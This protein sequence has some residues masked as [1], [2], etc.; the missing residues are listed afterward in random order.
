MRGLI[1]SWRDWLAV[2]GLA[3]LFGP[4]SAAGSA[5]EVKGASPEQSAIRTATVTRGDLV[6]TIT[7]NGTVE[8]E[9]LV[10]VAAPVAGTIEKFGPDPRGKTDPQ[11]QGKPID[12]GSPVEE[13]TVL[14]KLSDGT[15]MAQVEQAKAVCARAEAEMALAKT[16]LELAEAQ[17]RRGQEQM[18]NQSI[19]ASDLDVLKADHG[20]A[21]AS[22]SIAGATLAQTR[23]SL[24]Q[25]EINLANT[26]IKSPIR[27]VV[28]DRRVN[29]GQAA[30]TGAGA[31][32]LFL[33]ASDLSRMQVWVSINEADIARIRQ[34]QPARFSVDAY[35]GKSFEG[36]VSQIRLNAAVVQNVVTYTV[37]LSA[38]NP[39]GKLLPYLTANVRLEVERHKGAILVPNAALRWRPEPRWI[40]PEA[41]EKKPAGSERSGSDQGQ[42]GM[43]RPPGEAQRG[44]V[45]IR[46]GEFVRP[47]AVVIGPSDGTMTQISGDDVKEGLEVIVSGAI[48][49][50]KSS[51]RP[52]TDFEKALAGMGVNQLVVLP[53]EPA[54]SGA[55]IVPSNRSTLTVEDADEI[56]RQC[57]A[58]V[59]AAPVIRAR[60][61]V[62][63]GDCS[64]V[65]LS[66]LG[67]TPS[68]L[69]A[70][71]WDE[72]SEGDAFTDADVRYAKQVCLIGQ[73]LKRE[74][75]QGESPIGK[76]VR[77]ENVPF[78]VVGVL[79]RKGA[80]V[81]GL[82]QDDIMLAPWSTVRFRGSHSAPNEA[83]AGAG[84]LS[85]NQAR[86]LAN[87]YPG[88]TDRYGS[89]SSAQPVDAV[90]LVRS[91]AV[92][93]IL[94]QAASA[95]QVPRAIE[96]ITELLRQRHRIQRGKSDDFSVRDL[97]E[98]L[99][100]INSTRRW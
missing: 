90:Q 44:R 54:S 2:V 77:V 38:D 25:A 100:A 30:V 72:I 37:V 53:R 26:T 52:K 79:G 7:A 89:P 74:L 51:Q 22:I 83:G 24:K 73:T 17:W 85:A 88:S 49:A 61:A 13:G 8:A 48:A 47:I 58:V 34:Q 12:F 63:L 40:V 91:I 59:V 97:N 46:D 43:P 5:G 39:D 50:A 81:V 19:S 87:H 93:Q 36:K 14:A 57:P 82:D 15:Y 29:V 98:V 99:K 66:V 33:I 23:A 9:E 4:L 94:A 55:A 28:I 70:R 42:P 45:W 80:S 96:Q 31:P 67:T 35:P 20:V 18:K 65:P 84:S 92:D 86:A 3:M 64:W 76:D 32:S 71:D 10:D 41:R 6:V 21:Q 27:G 60:A 78:R 1:H 56:S 11:Y 68:Y 95:K 75:F 69:A 62:V 16:K